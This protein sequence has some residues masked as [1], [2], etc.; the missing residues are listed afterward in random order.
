MKDLETGSLWSHILG[1]AMR[2]PLKGQ[3]LQILPG[4]V[5]TWDE[6]RTMHPHTTV[7]IMERKPLDFAINTLRAG[8]KYVYGVRIGTQAKAWDY[9][10]LRQHPVIEESIENHPIWVVHEKDSGFT[11][12]YSRFLQNQVLNLVSQDDHMLTVLSS[13]G[14]LWDL[15]SGIALEG[16][17]KGEIL[18]IK[19]GIISFASSW[20]FFYP[21]SLYNAEKVAEESEFQGMGDTRN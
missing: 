10:Y 9:S 16:P 5:M 3:K 6:W 1:E 4:I 18:T 2:G 13:D 17:L 12:I 20:R 14:T 19:P 8:E 7:W 11:R 21:A 15:K